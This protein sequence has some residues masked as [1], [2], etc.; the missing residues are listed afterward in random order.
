MTPYRERVIPMLY[1]SVELRRVTNSCVDR[2]I[3]GGKAAEQVMDATFTGYLFGVG[4]R[5]QLS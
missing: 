1:V 4:T 3:F 5:D 2:N